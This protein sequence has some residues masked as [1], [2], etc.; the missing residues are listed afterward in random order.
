MVSVCRAA[1]LNAAY[2]A[3]LCKVNPRVVPLLVRSMEAFLW[4][5]PTEFLQ[6]LAE[7]GYSS[8]TACHDCSSHLSDCCIS[9]W[10]TGAND[11]SVLGVNR[12]LVG[13]S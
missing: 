5:A 9:V 4:S 3:L 8:M 6:F 10:K 13:V 12:G 7:V 1:A 2:E 11:V